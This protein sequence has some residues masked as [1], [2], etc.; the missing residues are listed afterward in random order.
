MNADD[1]EV[2]MAV[3]VVVPHGDAHSIASSSQA[4]LL[5]H[6]GKGSVAVVAVEAIPIART[7]L[8]KLGHRGPV[9]TKEIGPS[10]PV[11]IDDAESPRQRLR[12]ILVPGGS[13]TE[14]EVQPIA[15]STIE[16]ADGAWGV[17]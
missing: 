15:R 4:R 9:D 16:H 11:V 6:I 8:F 12:L 3:V 1:K 2:L 17:G 5:R 10:I 14:Q 7:G 13:G